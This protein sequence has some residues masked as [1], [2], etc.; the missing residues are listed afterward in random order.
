MSSGIPAT[1]RAVPG[2]RAGT[3]C[4]RVDAGASIGARHDEAAPTLFEGPAGG[5]EGPAPVGRLDD[6]GRVG[7]SADHPVPTRER[8][9]GRLDVGRRAPRS[10]RRRPATIAVARRSWARGKSR[11]WPEPRTATVGRPVGDDG[12]VGRPVDPHGKAR[13]DDDPDAG[14]ARPRSRPATRTPGLGR[15][16]RPDDGHGVPRREGRRADPGRRGPAAAP[17]APRRRA[18]YAS[19][20]RVTSSSPSRRRPLHER[21]AGPGAT[22]ASRPAMAARNRAAA[23][24]ERVAGIGACGNARCSGSGAGELQDP[25]RA[26]MVPEQAAEGRG[27]RPGTQAISAQ[28]SRSSIMAI[29]SLIAVSSLWPSARQAPADGPA[30]DPIPDRF[31]KVLEANPLGDVEVGDRPRHPERPLDPPGREP[32]CRHDRAPPDAL[33]RGRDGRRARRSAPASRPLT[34]PARSR[35]ADPGRRDPPGDHRARLRRGAGDQGARRR[36]GASRPTGRPGPGAD[37]RSG[38]RS[39]PGPPAGSRSRRPGRPRRHTGTGSSRRRAGSGPGGR[40][41]RRPGRSR[42]DRPRAGRAAP[43]GRRARTPAARRGRGRPRPPG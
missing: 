31:L 17:R 37:P 41:S 33:R 25:Q 3:R 34:T 28:A 4:S 24:V 13:D 20:S 40:P 35:A 26:S 27:P 38:R 21:A 8:P 22:T 10:R 42:R 29:S 39:A 36:P 23:V 43:R 7:Q 1:I 16:P 32:R 12:R 9:A 15:P 11:R 30:R 5:D 18:G 2:S 14:R 6:D 19:S